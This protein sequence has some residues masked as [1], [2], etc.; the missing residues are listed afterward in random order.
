MG[1]FLLKKFR[2]ILFVLSYNNSSGLVESKKCHHI[3]SRESNS[4]IE[5]EVEGK[6]IVVTP[7]HPFYIVGKGWVEAQYLTE[8]DVVLWM[9][10]T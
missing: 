8:D 10:R 9:I 1:K 4:W 7:E 2:I 6:K 5:I 3:F